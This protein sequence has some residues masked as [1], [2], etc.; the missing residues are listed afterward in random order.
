MVPHIPEIRG[1]FGVRMIPENLAEV[2]SMEDKKRGADNRDRN[3]EKALVE[4]APDNIVWNRGNRK[5]ENGSVKRRRGRRRS[6]R[7]IESEKQ[8]RVEENRVWARQASSE[9]CCAR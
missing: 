1:S 2:V 7:E 9:S 3:T 6:D 4:E 8:Q 5:V